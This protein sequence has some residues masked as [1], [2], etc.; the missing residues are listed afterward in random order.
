MLH[1]I[2]WMALTLSLLYP[3]IAQTISE[4]DAQILL[5]LKKSFTDGGTGAVLTSWNQSTS[6]ETWEGVTC[7]EEGRVIMMYV[8]D[9]T[10]HMLHVT[11]VSSAFRS[12]WTTT[13]LLFVSVGCG[14]GLWVGG[15]GRLSHTSLCT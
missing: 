5:D 12:V 7:N 15:L 13:E 9:V 1:L 8:W 10:L 4:V 11:Y 14:D 3:A 6:C 2:L